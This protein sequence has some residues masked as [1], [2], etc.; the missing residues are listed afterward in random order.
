MAEQLGRTRARDIMRHNPGQWRVAPMR[1][2][3][4]AYKRRSLA[5]RRIRAQTAKQK[6][7]GKAAQ[8][9][10]D[11]AASKR[12]LVGHWIPAQA[13]ARDVDQAADSE[14]T[15]ARVRPAVGS[16]A[17]GCLHC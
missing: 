11:E 5:G 17:A 6:G 1:G 8:A 2:Q 14:S 7:A 9:E 12:T 15:A 3:E 13:G 16:S 10:D 4:R